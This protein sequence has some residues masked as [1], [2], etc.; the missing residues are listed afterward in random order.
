MLK[1]KK[2]IRDLKH[3]SGKTYFGVYKATNQ[4]ETKN[5]DMSVFDIIRKLSIYEIDFKKKY[6]VNFDDVVYENKE[7]DYYE[8]DLDIESNNSYN[9]NSQVVFNYNIISVDDI[10]YITIKFHRY[11]DVRGNYT[12]YM[13]LNLSI[14]EFYE[15]IMDASRVE[16]L[17]ELNNKNYIISQNCLDESCIFQIDVQANQNYYYET[18]SDNAYLD[19]DNYR[20]INSIKKALKNYLQAA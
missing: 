7:G 13:V 18:L 5:L 19:I 14:D 1:A 10:Q 20:N 6:K 16:V 4:I 8:L 3:L 11:G 15:I 9:W 17:I 2:I 12:D